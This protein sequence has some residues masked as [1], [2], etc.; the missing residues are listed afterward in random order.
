MSCM[1]DGVLQACEGT[2]HDWT[3]ILHS[4]L[5][6]ML[7]DVISSYH[8]A[9]CL[10]EN[11]LQCVEDCCGGVD[12]PPE[13]LQDII[14]LVHHL[15]ADCPSGLDGLEALQ[16]FKSSISTAQFPASQQGR[17]VRSRAA[18][19]LATSLHSSHSIVT[20]ACKDQQQELDCYCSC[21]RES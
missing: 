10:A 16:K 17:A 2:Q 19:L 7:L 15:L 13:L 14:H 9:D 18:S 6:G 1:P 12:L 3:A 11:D 8:M 5:Q 21:I 4:C 20:C